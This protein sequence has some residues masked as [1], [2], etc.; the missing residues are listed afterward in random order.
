MR[1]TM[2][3]PALRE[4]LLKMREL[5]QA[6]QMDPKVNPTGPG[7]DER[8]RATYKKHNGRL[9]VILKQYGWPGEAMV[10]KDGSEAFWLLVQHADADKDLQRKALTALERAVAY[11]QASRPNLA[12]LADRV[13]VNSKQK[14]R[15][16]T[17]L[18][19]DSAAKPYPKP[20]E[21]EANLD[22]RRIAMGLETEAEYLKA[23][24]EGILIIRARLNG[25]PD[26]K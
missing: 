3:L 22:A 5:D 6:M 24:Y 17:Q 25:T 10:G 11:A 21:D 20:C 18:A 9:R 15:F 4:E 2:T 12:Y 1:Q 13:L 16:G 14:Q 19:W 23:A 8:T 26:K 7:H